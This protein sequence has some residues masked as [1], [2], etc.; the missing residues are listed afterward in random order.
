MCLVSTRCAFRKSPWPCSDVPF[1]GVMCL[2]AGACKWLKRCLYLGGSLSI[3]LLF[4]ISICLA[5]CK[6][7]Q[8]YP[9]IPEHGAMAAVKIVFITAWLPKGNVIVIVLC[10]CL[11][12]LTCCLE[13]HLQSL[14]E[15]LLIHSVCCQ[16]GVATSKTLV[17]RGSSFWTITSLIASPCMCVCQAVTTRGYSFWLSALMFAHLCSCS[18]KH[19]WNTV[20]RQQPS[21]ITAHDAWTAAGATRE[22]MLWAFVVL[23]AHL[24]AI[25]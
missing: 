12:P 16:V 14:Q 10:L 3:R 7:L 18:R 15:R 5:D 25:L 11:A 20:R 19:L 24:G 4:L 6:S 2:R 22:H 21:L 17:Q 23:V 13:I 8:P 9:Q 1:G